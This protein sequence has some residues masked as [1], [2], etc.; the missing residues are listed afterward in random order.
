MKLFQKL[1]ICLKTKIKIG[2]YERGW[3]CGVE[4]SRF[5]QAYGTNTC[6]ALSVVLDKVF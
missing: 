3:R 1:E 5:L 4:W 2:K 6:R